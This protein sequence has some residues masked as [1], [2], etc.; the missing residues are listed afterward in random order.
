TFPVP[1]TFHSAD[2]TSFLYPRLFWFPIRSFSGPFQPSRTI[3]LRSVRPCPSFWRS[4]EILRTDARRYSEKTRHSNW[5]CSLVTLMT[6]PPFAHPPVV[7]PANLS[8]H[9]CDSVRRSA[10][11]A[12]SPQSFLGITS[13][14]SLASASA[15]SA[16]N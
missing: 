15:A 1:H 8:S 5:P 13:S 4:V 14:S 11:A 3:A 16:H 10:T 2:S 6:P 9:G 7:I 12:A